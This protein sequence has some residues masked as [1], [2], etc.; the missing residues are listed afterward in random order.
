MAP[1]SNV[2]GVLQNR[3]ELAVLIQAYAVS[4]FYRSLIAAIAPEIALDLSLGETALGTLASAFYVG[5]A[6]AQIPTG[7]MLDRHGPRLT[8]SLFTGIAVCG[9]AVFA[10]A[11]GFGM[12][13]AGQ[14][15]LGVGCAP[16]FTGAMV[17]VGKKYADRDFAFITALIIAVG[18][19]GDMASTAPLSFLSEA[20]GWRGALAVF[21]GLTALSMVLSYLALADSATPDAARERSFAEMILGMVNV[22]RIRQLW[23]IIPISLLG[24]AVLMTVRGLWAGPFLNDLYD[25]STSERGMGLLGMSVAMAVGTFVY[26]VVDKRVDNRKRIVAGGSI[27]VSLA[28]AGAAVAAGQSGGVPFALAAFALV[29]F[30][31]FTYPVLMGHC[32]R[33]L[34]DAVLGRGMAVLTLVNFAGVALLQ[35]TTGALMESNLGSM[36]PVEAYALLFGLLSLLLL[37]STLVYSRSDNWPGEGHR[38][39]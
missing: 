37:V 6:L 12:A 36:T 32:R 13:L 39:S 1:D 20:F 26:G 28:L 34:G 23:P 27:M 14:V 5:F 10:G 19:L 15:M 24:Y 31:G 30:F 35:S 17:V 3:V 22:C 18:S 2:A 33:F 16:I 7:M 9:G 8:I 11:N 4:L 38:G 21:V 29:G 25:L